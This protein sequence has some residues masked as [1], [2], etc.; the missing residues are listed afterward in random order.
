MKLALYQFSPV[1]GD[2]KKN[3]E[4][5]INISDSVAADIIVF[6]ELAISGY[7]FT[8]KI[9]SKAMAEEYNKLKVY[10][11]LSLVA[12][13]QNKIIIFGFPELAEDKIFNSAQLIFPNKDYNRV[14]RKSH[15]FYKEKYAFD[16][17]DSGFFTV[18]YPEFDINIGTMICYDWRFPESA[19]TLALQGADLIVCPSNLVTNIWTKVMPARAIENKV[20]LA[21]ANRV[22]TEKENGEVLD[23]NGLSAV[24]SYNGDEMAMASS[25][26]E[27]ILI[28]EIDPQLTRNKSFNPENNIFSDRKP[29]LYFK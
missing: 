3:S 14:Y 26:N 1:Y 13:A 28:T 10:E 27:E 21:V 18:N 20:Y 16:A 7:F 9:Q 11:E 2:C 23:F 25:N 4:T 12:K 17:G 5:I 29:E 8:D 6:P 22:G 24:Y 19:R 15:L